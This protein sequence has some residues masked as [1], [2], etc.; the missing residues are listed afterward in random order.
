[1]KILITGAAGLVGKA[2][3][4]EHPGHEV[5]A[6]RHAD[7]DITDPDSI[8]RVVS[9]AAPDLVFNCAVIGVDDCERD[10]ALA[11]AVNVEGP[12]NLARAATAAGA[13]MVHFSTNYVFDGERPSLE[14][15]T[16]EDAAAP[17]NE[18]GRT[19]LGGEAAVVRECAQSFVIRT[20]WVFGKDKTSFLST[21]PAALQR[22]E[23]VRA[24]S[25]TWASTTFVTDLVPRVREILERGVPGVYQVVNEGVCSYETFAHE[26]ARICG[27]ADDAAKRLISVTTEKELQR[28]APR[29]RWTAM[30]C[31]LSERI[32]LAPMRPWQEALAEYIRES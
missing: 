20:S 21:T 28:L 19:K 9:D 22:G 30:R 7:L 1:M 13:T 6:L 32:A 2:L 26:A 5:L 10:P 17:I 8:R 27:L 4:R 12:A 15:Y 16:I 11:R 18:Y 31:L 25:D 3:A 29:P 24:I 23:T 14:P